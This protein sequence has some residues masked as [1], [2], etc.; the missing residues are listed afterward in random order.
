[1]CFL[2]PFPH[3][4]TYPRHDNFWARRNASKARD[5]DNEYSDEHVKEKFGDFKHWLKEAM[6]KQKDGNSIDR[7]KFLA[8]QGI[9]SQERGDKIEFKKLKDLVL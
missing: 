1:M 9:V 6:S 3:H 2:V 5:F 7:E 4:N 8:V